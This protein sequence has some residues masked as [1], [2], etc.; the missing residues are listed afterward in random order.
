M[1]TWTRSGPRS[2]QSLEGSTAL[3]FEDKDRSRLAPLDFCRLYHVMIAGFTAFS[4]VFQEKRPVAI[5]AST[6][7]SI[8][9]CNSFLIAMAV[10]HIYTVYLI[11]HSRIETLC[12]AQRHNPELFFSNPNLISRCAQP[13][14]SLR[15]PVQC[16]PPCTPVHSYGPFTL[17][18]SAQR[19]S[20]SI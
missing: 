4:S 19:L 17:L 20:C 8:C 1:W 13:F 16:H 18:Q 15:H 7:L 9:C 12:F 6:E 3:L 5:P 14:S 10:N 2:V 11:M